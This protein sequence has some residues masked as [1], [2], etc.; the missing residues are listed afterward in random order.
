MQANCLLYNP[1]RDLEKE[2][3]KKK[4]IQFALKSLFKYTDARVQGVQFSLEK[5][6]KLLL[7]V[8][9]KSY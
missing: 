7:E 9:N 1:L 5:K 2:V 8:I 3:V 6:W 4:N